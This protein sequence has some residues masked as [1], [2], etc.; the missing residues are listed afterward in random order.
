MPSRNLTQ[1]QLEYHDR[2][3]RRARSAN[4]DRPDAR[5]DYFA[6]AITSLDSRM[7]RAARE[8]LRLTP[9]IIASM[10]V[11]SIDDAT[12]SNPTDEIRAASHEAIRAPGNQCG[13]TFGGVC[14]DA[15]DHAKG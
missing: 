1:E 15:D 14:I 4:E 9:A 12:A 8:H 3:C 7:R 10:I 2:A 6:A 11:A 13:T 5:R